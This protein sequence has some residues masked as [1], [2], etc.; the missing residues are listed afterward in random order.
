MR[1]SFKDEILKYKDALR[2]KN[3]IDFDAE[4][5]TEKLRLA[6]ADGRKILES[7]QA[8]TRRLHQQAIERRSE[9]ER[10]YLTS[11][12]DD[13]IQAKTLEARLDL[14]SKEGIELFAKYAVASVDY[15]LKDYPLSIESHL[16]EEGR[17]LM[18]EMKLPAIAELNWAHTSKRLSKKDTSP[19]Q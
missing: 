2:R 3:D 15:G 12:L 4:Q 9:L 16:E 18:L 13:Q 6:I 7:I 17:I 10:K 1:S 8:E 5:T 11:I 14:D 19:H